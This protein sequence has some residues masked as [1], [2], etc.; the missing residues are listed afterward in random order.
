MNKKTIGY[1]KYLASGIFYAFLFLN[2]YSISSQ[3]AIGYPH[4]SKA[5]IS[6][7]K[8]E[9]DG[10]LQQTSEAANIYQLN[11]EWD[12]IYHCQMVIYQMALKT[13]YSKVW[14]PI[15][16]IS[17]KIPSSDHIHSYGKSQYLLAFV[18]SQLGN[19]LSTIKHYKKA[20]PSIKNSNDTLRYAGILGNL[21]EEYEKLGNYQS[22]IIYKSKSVELAKSLVG[23]DENYFRHLKGLAQ[24]FYHY[25][26]IGNAK[27][28]I[29]LVDSLSGSHSF[30]LL[31]RINLKEKNYAKA[32]E[33]VNSSL[34]PKNLE[35]Q[36]KPYFLKLKADILAEQGKIVKA[37]KI[38][39]KILPFHISIEDK[40]ERGKFLYAHA[41]MLSRNKKWDEAIKYY[42][43]SLQN[44]TSYSLKEFSNIKKKSFLFN[45]IWIADIYAATAKTYFQFYKEDEKS[46]LLD[47]AKVYYDNALYALDQKR[48]LLTDFNGKHNLT[49][50]S[51]RIFEQAIQL[52]LDL[53]EKYNDTIYLRSSFNFAE[54][55]NAF[56]LRQELKENDLLDI[57]DI[58]DEDKEKYLRKKQDFVELS[59]QVRSSKSDT[60]FEK[61]RLAQE[62]F[63]DF[64]K[65]I[66]NR[67]AKYRQLTTDY[68]TV[69]SREIQKQLD[70]NTGLVKYF[71]GEKSVVVFIMT[72]HTLTYNIVKIESNFS[73][74]VEKYR[75]LLADY[76][77][78]LP[79][80][81]SIK[82]EFIK[83]S[84]FIYTKIAMP[85][86]ENFPNNITHV[87]IAPDGPLVQIPFESLVIDKEKDWAN[88]KAYLLTKY[89]ISYIYFCGQLLRNQ[90][91]DLI[92]YVTTY[93]IE[94]DEHT[95]S[96]MK[97][98]FGDTSNIIQSQ[99]FRS[100]DF[101][102]LYFADDEA[103]EVS[104]IFGGKCYTNRDAT[105]STFLKEAGLSDLIHISAHSFV[106]NEFPEN[107]CIIF[108][109]TQKEKENLLTLID[110][111][112]L[113]LD[114]KLVT[115][116][117]CNTFFGYNLEG[118][119]LMSLARSFIES[120]ADGVVGSYWSVPDEVSKSFMEIFYNNLKKG[121]SKS[122][123]LRNTK[124][125][126]LTNDEISNPFFRSP[127]Y[128]SSWVLFG[129]SKPLNVPEPKPY[130]PALLTLFAVVGGVLILLF[131]K[132]SRIN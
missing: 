117:A 115:L 34:S 77:S 69:G 123:A 71:T 97:K 72:K 22:A 91:P 9:F 31:T 67:Y 110:I 13:S 27:K 106:D 79:S 2:T 37:L 116:S 47:M 41:H 87:I 98:T 107:S 7:S 35:Y 108:N 95:L 82:N 76:K 17:K 28:Y 24:A 102:T 122:E 100:T 33:Y 46:Q 43:L 3:S 109:K 99:K 26:D 126:Y 49:S 68:A 88:P 4:L 63:I 112:K 14:D 53:F 15:N 11:E 12:S 75:A 129:D 78:F 10:V 83:L 6:L 94:Y 131:M 45:E 125:E 89:A 29:R 93:G 96:Y 65:K 74:L 16:Q 23:N 121:H 114:A 21:A 30:S 119:G 39:Q 19:T 52:N 64:K 92:N 54:R 85:F 40:R 70:S 80:Q 111:Y 124:I 25:G 60:L 8:N 1:R 118:E 59:F 57:S 58:S 32:M 44:F 61:F 56:I 113:N 20:I 128:W 90:D 48:G 42:D 132:N 120:G 103:K 130:L 18:Q 5:K 105:K 101:T 55:Y 86:V 73:R 38:Y 51:K 50:I 127:S 84:H 104:K 66:S 36:E 81:D 62:S